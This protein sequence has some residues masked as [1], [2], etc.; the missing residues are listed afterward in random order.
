M[1]ESE[2]RVI[3]LWSALLGGERWA[4]RCCKVL[5][6]AAADAATAEHAVE[7]NEGIGGADG[8]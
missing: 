6:E 4:E 2:Q 8:G 5:E 3:T 1:S 7:A